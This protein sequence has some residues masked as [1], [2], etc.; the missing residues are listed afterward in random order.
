MFTCCIHLFLTIAHRVLFLGSVPVVTLLYLLHMSVILQVDAFA[1]MA[2]AH[3]PPLLAVLRSLE[4]DG[5]VAEKGSPQTA[6]LPR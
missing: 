1:P 2:F 3:V 4:L 5:S 6:T